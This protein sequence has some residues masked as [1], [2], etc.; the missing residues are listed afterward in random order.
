MSDYKFLRVAL[1]CTLLSPIANVIVLIT[2]PILS[3]HFGTMLSI[4]REDHSFLKS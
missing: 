4:V 2:L 3:C 1:T